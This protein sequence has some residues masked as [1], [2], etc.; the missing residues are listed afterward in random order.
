MS[1]K[2]LIID[3][4]GGKAAKLLTREGTTGQIVYTEAKLKTVRQSKFFVN[5]TFGMDMN[6]NVTFGGTP[7][8]I[9][10][11]GDNAG[12]T[13]AIG[14]GTWNFAD[15]ATPQAG[16]NHVSITAAND[17]DFASFTDATETDM[18]SHTAI[19]GQ[20]QLVAY[21]E[22][23]NSTI[24]QFR[25]NGLDVG[26]SVDLNDFMNPAILG[27]YQGFVV[28]KDEM[29]A[30]DITV[31]ELTIT[32]V[33]RSGPRPTIFFDVLQIENT[34]TPARF[35]VIPDKGTRLHVDR[36][37][38]QWIDVG[39]GGTAHAYNKIGALSALSNGIVLASRLLG[40]PEFGFPVRQLSDILSVGWSV[41]DLVDDGTNTLVKVQL[42][43]DSEERLILDS[44]TGDNQ[45][46]TIND[47]LS[48]LLK[49]T[50]I[51]NG[52]VEQI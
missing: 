10:D 30:S 32:I 43:I 13:G 24:L 6:Q 47:D 37:L 22:A 5:P 49:F 1:I 12:W 31:D 41:K 48:G 51:T 11:G 16:T 25:N 15:T 34:G 38:M 20:I 33:R 14:V 9:H 28:P 42:F 27:S 4:N 44:R 26:T 45:S 29:S 19:T 8:L 7:E 40:R 23:L 35:E 2:T 50:A 17:S 36:V 3:G 39:T 46:I 21:N 18:S 52:R